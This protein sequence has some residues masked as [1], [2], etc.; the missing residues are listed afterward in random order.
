MSLLFESAHFS[1]AGSDLIIGFVLYFY[2]FAVFGWLVEMIYLATSGRGLI[3]SG[4]LQGPVC[5]AYAAGVLIIYPATLLFAP[6][7]FWAQCILYVGLATIVE[8][9]AHLTL[10]KIL[11]MRIW[12]YSDEFM[13]YQGRISLKYTFFWFILVLLLVLVLQP[14]AIALIESLS[15]LTRLRVAGILG[16]VLII[17]YI[18]SAVMFFRMTKRIR[19]VCSKF[20]LPDKEM[21]DLQFN[22]P[23]I[24]NEKKRLAK[25]SADPE[26]VAFEQEV[27][28]R[29]F[30]GEQLDTL[31]FQLGDYSD[32]IDHPRYRT[33]RV[34]SAKSTLTYYTYL[35]IAELTYAFCLSEDLDGKA[36]ARGMLLS[37]Y[38]SDS[39]QPAVRLIDFL[40]PQARIMLA[41]FRDIGPIGR[42][43]RDV[44]LRYKWPLNFGPPLTPE[45]LI[46]SFAEKLVHSREFRKVLSSLYPEAPQREEACSMH[47]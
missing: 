47:I 13:N 23:R 5:P 26:F 1:L 17:D 31:G 37:A 42:I 7:P 14:A 40:I 45:C 25:L 46:A 41:V 18:L 28:R 12:D 44:L 6:L 20:G 11:G 24:M 19:R 8:Y 36:A 3:N 39:M 35:R 33:W 29:L 34:A 22:R 27:S 2:L 16:T 15:S 9:T 30:S 32:I 43:E 21:Q 4:F 10:E 38:R